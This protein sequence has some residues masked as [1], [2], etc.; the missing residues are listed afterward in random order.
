L[1]NASPYAAGTSVSISAVPNQGYVFTNWTAPAGTFGNSTAG[2]TTF[3]MPT[4]NVTV[5]ANFATE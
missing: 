3:T 4:Q 5:T 2:N 1:T